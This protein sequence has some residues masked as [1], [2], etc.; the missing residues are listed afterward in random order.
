VRGRELIGEIRGRW[1]AGEVLAEK[2]VRRQ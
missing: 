1:H 2:R